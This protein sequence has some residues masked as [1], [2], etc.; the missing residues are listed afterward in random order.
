MALADTIPSREM[1]HTPAVVANNGEVLAPPYDMRSDMLLAVA[2][3]P[4]GPLRAGFPGVPFMSV[5]GRTPVAVWFAKVTVGCHRISTGERECISDRLSI[6]Y[7]EL[8]VLA[9]LDEP[10]AF[11]PGIYTTSKLVLRIG[12]LY[13]MAKRPAHATFPRGGRLFRSTVQPFTNSK[14]SYVR[15]RIVGSGRPLAWFAN[16][17][18][19]F[20]SPTVRFPTGTSVRVVLPSVRR[21]NLALV[22]D[23]Y[24]DVGESWLPRPVP[25]LPVGVYLRDLWMHMPVPGDLP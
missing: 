3:C 5:R 25:F 6:P 20:T 11:V 13:G 17:V 7:S 23:G 14:S 22:R 12:D 1:D 21:A 24:L 2:L 19:P 9:A 10:A 16:R 8:T 4:T 15:A 18:M